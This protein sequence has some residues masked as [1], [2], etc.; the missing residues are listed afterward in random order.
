MAEDPPCRIAILIFTA[1][2][3]LFRAQIIGYAHVKIVDDIPQAVV[4][5]AVDQRPLAHA[6]A[7]TR[8]AEHVRGEVH[9][10]LAA[11]GDD[12]GIAQHDVLRAQRDLEWREMLATLPEDGRVLTDSWGPALT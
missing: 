5:H 10:L 3:V 7:G 1:D 6:H 2:I 11:R 12:G 8:A 4:D 9:V